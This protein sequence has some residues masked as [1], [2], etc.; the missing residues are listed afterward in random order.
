MKLYEANAGNLKRVRIFIA[1]KKLDV[2]CV[3]LK[4]VTDT[5]APEFLKINPLG[6]VPALEL[7]GGQ[8]IT[9]TLAICQYLEAAL[10][11]ANAFNLGPTKDH[12][13]L[14]RWSASMRE[15]DSWVA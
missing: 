13:H 14:V 7:D 15:R 3:L 12:K 9:E 8:I 2:L 5:R 4:L 11:I 1:E 10:F 6:E